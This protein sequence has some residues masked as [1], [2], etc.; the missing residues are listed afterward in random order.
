MHPSTQDDEPA[1][2]RS[3]P[4]ASLV[5]VILAGGRARRFGGIDKGLVEVAGRPMVDWIVEAVRP[6]VDT[7]L[8]IANRNAERYRATG[9]RVLG[10]DL[11]DFQ[12]PL[13]G[14]ATAMAEVAAD[15]ALLTVPCDS[16]LPPP[17]LASRL[18]AA[19]A[20]G[21]AEL[22]VAHDGERLQCVHALI[23]GALRASLATFLA[24]GGRKVEDWYA[25][26][27]VATADFADCRRHFV[28]LNRLEDLAG[29]EALL[30]S[31][32]GT[33]LDGPA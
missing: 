8:I 29:V 19:L 12:G 23:P 13:A 24:E 7:L 20:A 26:H 2:A 4:P 15:G 9:L 17:E 3:R 22:A 33:R 16:P 28:N 21:G 18:R 30:C 14:I 1:P 6:Q 31:A 11:P 10:D 27:R 5:G 32:A 25:R